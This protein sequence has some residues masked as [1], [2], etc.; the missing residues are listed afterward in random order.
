MYNS[1]SALCL[2]IALRSE[3]ILQLAC[4]LP[5]SL[6]FLVFSTLHLQS[7]HWILQVNDDVSGGSNPQ[8]IVLPKVPKFF[9]AAPSH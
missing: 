7:I 4:L 6:I 3:A 1:V 5:L 9:S 2:S 8:L